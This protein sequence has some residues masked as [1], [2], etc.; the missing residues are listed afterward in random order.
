M[1]LADIGVGVLLE[2]CAIRVEGMRRAKQEIEIMELRMMGSRKD[3]KYRKARKGF[4]CVLYRK[5][6]KGFDCVLSRK[7]RKEVGDCVLS[8]LCVFAVL[9]VFARNL[10][11]NP[12]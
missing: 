3:A 4:D 10:T 6:R 1:G 7:A 11:L 2:V 9:C 12:I 5:A 8:S